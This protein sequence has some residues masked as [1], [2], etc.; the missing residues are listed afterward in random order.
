MIRKIIRVDSETV[1]I[2]VPEHYVGKMLEIIA[3]TKDEE[4]I[5]NDLTRQKATF[6]ALSLDTRDFK[7][8]RE[9]ANER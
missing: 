1:F 3:F 7:F 6:K 2:N 4:I 9:E 8:D 5:Y